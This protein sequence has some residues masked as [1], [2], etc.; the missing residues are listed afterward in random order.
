MSYGGTIIGTGTLSVGSADVFAD[1][2][3]IEGTARAQF[4]SLFANNIT[5][6]GGG[7][8]LSASGAALELGKG[9]GGTSG[10][11]ARGGSHG[12]SGG[13]PVPGIPGISYG[14]CFVPAAPGSQGGDSGW[15][16]DGK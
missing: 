15:I 12:G 7:G 2:V 9:R 6:A 13:A 16:P 10:N 14:S 8:T 5:I 3:L 1:E 4:V 11:F